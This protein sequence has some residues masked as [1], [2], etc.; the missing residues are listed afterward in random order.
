[1][2]SPSDVKVDIPNGNQPLLDSA[3]PKPNP[4]K[5]AILSIVAYFFVCVFILIDIVM[6]I[7]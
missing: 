6:H 2:S 7:M 1:M 4:I 3:P 5:I